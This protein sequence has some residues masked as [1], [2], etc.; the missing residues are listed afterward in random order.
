MQRNQ[1]AGTVSDLYYEIIN[2]TKDIAYIKDKPRSVIIKHSGACLYPAL[3]PKEPQS[4][5]LRLQYLNYIMY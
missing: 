3:V 5:V 4:F 1:Q 2:D